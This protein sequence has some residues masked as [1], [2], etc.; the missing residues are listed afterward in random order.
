LIARIVSTALTDHAGRDPES[1]GEL[2]HWAG[3]ACPADE[4]DGGTVDLQQW[5]GATRVD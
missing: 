2:F 5:K 4:L 3:V 1:A